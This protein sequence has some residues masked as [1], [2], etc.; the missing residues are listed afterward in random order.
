M[1]MLDFNLSGRDT[2]LNYVFMEAMWD[3]AEDASSFATDG[4]IRYYDCDLNRNYGDSLLRNLKLVAQTYTFS[5]L[6][7][8]AAILLYRYVRPFRWTEIDEIEKVRIDTAKINSLFDWIE[9]ELTPEDIDF[10]H[11]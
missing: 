8:D 1:G 6:E 5:Q 3:Y 4:H 10:E 7:K 11:I 2:V 9:N